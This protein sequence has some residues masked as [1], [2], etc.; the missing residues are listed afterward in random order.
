LG[1]FLYIAFLA[2]VLVLA[3]GVIRVL[4]SI[5]YQL[6]HANVLARSKASRSAPNDT[7]RSAEE[8]FNR[9]YKA[10]QKGDYQMAL[11]IL[12]DTISAEPSYTEAYTYRA[13]THRA[14]GHD[15]LARRDMTTAKELET[16][17]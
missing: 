13:L 3:G 5:E 4:I 14:L 10:Y 7:H 1:T 17:E 6:H 16:H 8:M 2:F 11:R 15:D 12:S 9:G